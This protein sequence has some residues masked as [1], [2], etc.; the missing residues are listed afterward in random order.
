MLLLNDALNGHLILQILDYFINA[1]SCS[2]DAVLGSL[3]GD[4]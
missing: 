4:L 1:L 2:I 3:E